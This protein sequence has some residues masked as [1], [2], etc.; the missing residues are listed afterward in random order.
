RLHDLLRDYAR[1]LAAEGDS[2]DHIQAVQRVCTYYLAALTVANG[3]IVRSGAAVPPAPDDASRMETPV[4][5]SRAGALSRLETERA[6]HLAAVRRAN[7]FSL[8]ALVVRLAAAMAPFLRQAG[9]WDQA[10]GLHRT[11]AEAASRTGD[12]RARGDALAE[13]GVVRRFMAAY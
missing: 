12:Q 7:G 8:Y 2:M 5:E 1:G 4:L 9:P 3:H 13:L 10:V 11:A 6:H